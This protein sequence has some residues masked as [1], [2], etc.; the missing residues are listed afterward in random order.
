MMWGMEMRQ[1]LA[2]KRMY[3]EYCLFTEGYSVYIGMASTL[4][5][6]KASIIKIIPG[7]GMV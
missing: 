6:R 7:S 3:E 4:Y 1:R 2:E 5:C